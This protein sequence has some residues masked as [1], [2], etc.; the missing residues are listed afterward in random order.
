MRRPSQTCESQF[1]VRIRV[2]IR[3]RVKIRVSVR[4]RV[5]GQVRD[6]EDTKSR[7]MICA[8]WPFNVLKQGMPPFPLTPSIQA[9]LES[10]NLT[11]PSS[12]AEASHA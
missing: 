3:V 12:L 4:V 5:R 1:R 11:V 7:P 2:R 8:V 6:Y 9:P 10:Y